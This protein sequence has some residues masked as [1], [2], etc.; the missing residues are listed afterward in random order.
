MLTNG[1]KQ[2]RLINSIGVPLF[3]KVKREGDSSRQI[4]AI[5]TYGSE[6]IKMK[7]GAFLS[8]EVPFSSA[9]CIITLSPFAMALTLLLCRH[10]EKTVNEETLL[11]SH[12]NDCFGQFYFFRSFGV[13]FRPDSGPDCTFGS[14]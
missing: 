3:L 9:M 1:A 5:Y 4:V 10:Q 13:H 12:K 11:T 2:D 8:P 7:L 14:N 6:E